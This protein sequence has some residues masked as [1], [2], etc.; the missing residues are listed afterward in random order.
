MQSPLLFTC[1]LSLTHQDVTGGAIVQCTGIAEN[2]WNSM[3]S[4]YLCAHKQNTGSKTATPVFGPFFYIRRLPCQSQLFPI[5]PRRFRLRCT[6]R[7]SKGC[8]GECHLVG[9]YI[10]TF[11]NISFFSWSYKFKH[12]LISI[13]PSFIYSFIHPFNRCL[14][15]MY[16]V[17]NSMLGSGSTELNTGDMSSL[18]RIMS[19]KHDKSTGYG[20]RGALCLESLQDPSN[21]F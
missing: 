10:D 2:G 13:I 6:G 19:M 16:S 20:S 17:P 9:N 8:L 7:V 18:A 1:T 11:Q 4:F 3:N 15:S 21:T 12:L 5:H 14:L